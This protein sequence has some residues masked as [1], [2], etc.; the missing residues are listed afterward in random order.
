MTLLQLKYF[1]VLS[2]TG[3]FTRAAN[4]VYTSQPTMSRQIQMLEEEL[5]Y[6]LFNR[7]SKPIRL[8]EPGQILYEGVKEAISQINYTLDMAKIAS[9]GKN[10][11]L[12]IS[13]QSGYYSEYM[14][15]PIINELR[16]NWPSLQIRCSKLFSWEQI[17]G[18]E[19][20]SI[21]IA[22]GL[23]FPHWDKAGFMVKPL[24]EVE[25]LIVM[26]AHHRLANKKCLEYNDLCGE[27]FFLTAPNGYQVDK[28]FKDCF[29]LTNVHQV[30]VASSEIAY[31]KVLSDNGLTISNPYDPVLLNSSHYHSVKFNTEYSDSYVCVVNP[32]NTNP[33]IKLFLDLIDRRS[34][35]TEK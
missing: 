2:E 11:S 33:V 31:F 32:D 34:V 6:A 29:D 13:F 8:T 28:V 12:N 23:E 30:E 22:I 1:I 25:T 19:N 18:L 26:S 21:D 4:Q 20:G 35:E 16:E 17:K 9:E 15:F 3:N 14:F 7:N 10:G 5:G 27:T 24:K